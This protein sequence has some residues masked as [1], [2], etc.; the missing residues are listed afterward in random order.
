MEPIVRDLLV[1][2]GHDD[3]FQWSWR[4]KDNQQPLDFAG[5]SLRMQIRAKPRDPVLL[6]E[7]RPQDL[8]LDEGS[9][10]VKVWF[11]GVVSET[12]TFK[13]GHYDLELYWPDDDPVYRL[14]MGKIAINPEVT[15]P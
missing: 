14:V 7:M 10:T 6:F 1:Y 13:K 5:A 4:N 8:E 15:M 9:A 11:R 2:Q 12:F 3:V